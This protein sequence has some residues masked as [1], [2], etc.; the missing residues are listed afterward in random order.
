MNW[1]RRKFLVSA[2]ALPALAGLKGLKIGVTDWNLK[3]AGKLEAVALAKKLDFEGV[4]VSLGRQA[5]D[6]KLPLDNDELIGKYLAESKKQGI[7]LNGTCLD[8]LHVNYLKNDKLGQKWV[9]DSIPVTKKLGAKV[10]LLPF[11]GKGALTSP[12]EM[13]YVADALKDVAPMAQTA[14]VILGLENT[15][16]AQDNVRI[17]DRI[18]SKAV[19]IYYDVGNS[20]RNGFD[21][22]RE[23]EWLG[24]KRICQFHFKDNPGYLGEGKVD[25][26]AVL[27]SISHSDFQ[28]Y[29][30]LETDSPSKSIEAD[31]RRN[32]SY[33]RRVMVET[34]HA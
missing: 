21:A 18:G 9:A 31:M 3:L 33:L 25:M 27:K 1:S 26:K 28:G 13:D 32:L 20:T 15:I 8:I 19:L 12:A 17:L 22:P 24:T 34:K 10:I 16:S 11:F 2:A 23:I 6:N 14:G 7:R 5:E 30:N 4:Q 29:A